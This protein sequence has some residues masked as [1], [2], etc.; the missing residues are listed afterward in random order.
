MDEVITKEVCLHIMINLHIIMI[1]MFYFY[2]ILSNINLSEL[3]KIIFILYI[4][5]WE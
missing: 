5:G 2:Q 1:K 3:F 4:K